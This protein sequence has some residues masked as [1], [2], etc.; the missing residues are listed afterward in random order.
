M[1]SPTFCSASPPENPSFNQKGADREKI[2]KPSSSQGGD[3]CDL[4]AK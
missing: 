1:S 4:S 2:Q 3:V